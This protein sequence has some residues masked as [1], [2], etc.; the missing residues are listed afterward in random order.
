MEER[1]F[2]VEIV[3]PEGIFYDS[4]AYKIEFRTTEGER[5][6]YGGHMPETMILVPCTF[7]ITEKN[8]RKKAEL[9]S[10]FLEIQP[11]KAVVLSEK[12]SW[13]E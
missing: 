12:A 4:E 7:T 11:E 9:S 1:H 8:G 13:I 6:V 2:R 3:T 10:G 5:G